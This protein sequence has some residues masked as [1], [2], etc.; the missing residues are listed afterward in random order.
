MCVCACVCVWFRFNSRAQRYFERKE[1]SVRNLANG[2]TGST[3]MEDLN[4]DATAVLLKKGTLG[5]ELIR[6]AAMTSSDSEAAAVTPLD[7]AVISPSC[8]FR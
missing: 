7:L 5:S 1:K 2:L 4:C 3:D 6:P 8:C